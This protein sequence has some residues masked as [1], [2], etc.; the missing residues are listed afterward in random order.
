MMTRTTLRAA[1]IAGCHVS[2]LLL[3]VPRV[4]ADHRHHRHSHNVKVHPHDRYVP[5]T[6]ALEH[7]G[8]FAPFHTGRVYHRAHRHY[9]RA[10]RFPVIVDGHVVYRPFTYCDGRLFVSAAAP[11]PRLAVDIVF[12]VGRDAYPWWAYEPYPRYDDGP[13]RRHRWH[14][15]EHDGWGDDEEDD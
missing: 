12:G 14:D 11:R 8:T 2:A 1:I 10:Y 15:D 3:F 4:E 13:Y 5:R 9:H 7:R 6:I